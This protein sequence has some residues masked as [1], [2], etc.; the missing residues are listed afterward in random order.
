MSCAARIKEGHNKN[1]QYNGKA[2]E[3]RMDSDLHA[4]ESIRFDWCKTAWAR[5]CLVR[6]QTSEH[7]S[8]WQSPRT[9]WTNGSISHRRHVAPPRRQCCINSNVKALK[10]ILRT[11]FIP[12]SRQELYRIRGSGRGRLRVGSCLHK[13]AEPGFAPA[14]C[15]S[16]GQ[17]DFLAEER[18]EM[19]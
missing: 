5:P 17:D 6:R 3:R 19:H 14:P 10:I 9:P 7:E 4:R 12:S 15:W 11:R 2:N 16:H 18:E 1:E 8:S 13:Y